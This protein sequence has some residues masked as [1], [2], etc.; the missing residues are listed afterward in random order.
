MK[1]KKY[2]QWLYVPC[3]RYWNHCFNCERGLGFSSFRI[4]KCE[5][6]GSHEILSEDMAFLRSDY[7]PPT[8]C[9]AILRHNFRAFKGSRWSWLPWLVIFGV[10]TWYRRDLQRQHYLEMF[11]WWFNE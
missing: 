6:C 4:E 10:M 5:R 7:A 2:W 8:G 3:G 11:G 1:M 9:L